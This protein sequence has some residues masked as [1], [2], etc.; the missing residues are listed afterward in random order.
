MYSKETPLGLT[1]GEFR[2]LTAEFP[3]HAE[4]LLRRRD[5]L[6]VV[7]EYHIISN[8]GMPAILLTDSPITPKTDA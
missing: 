2:K 5:N 6:T 1:V 3:D 7:C 4:I 8:C